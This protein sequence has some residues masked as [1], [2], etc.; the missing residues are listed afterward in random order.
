MEVWQERLAEREPSFLRPS[1]TF[2]EKPA[3]A[4]RNFSSWTTRSRT[5]DLLADILI[6]SLQLGKAAPFHGGSRREPIKRRHHSPPMDLTQQFV[7]YHKTCIETYCIGETRNPS[8]Y[9]YSDL[10]SAPCHL[11]V[12]VGNGKGWLAETRRSLPVGS[13]PIKTRPCSLFDV[14]PQILVEFT[15]PA[16]F[17]FPN[18]WPVAHLAPFP[19]MADSRPFSLA[20]Q[21][22][23]RRDSAFPSSRHTKST[24]NPSFI[25]EVYDIP[26]DYCH[27][28]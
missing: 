25:L 24:T 12:S 6:V 7:S 26:A 20:P 10:I 19:P 14:D 3:L 22:P 18:P 13:Y 28:C 16:D 15:F 4:R 21:L 27:I 1:L 9:G 11:S 2:W 5:L 17:S 23:P 8:P